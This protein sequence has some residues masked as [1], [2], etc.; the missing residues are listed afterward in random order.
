MRHFK[1][2]LENQASGARTCSE[3]GQQLH[4]LGCATAARWQGGSAHTSSSLGFQ[5]TGANSAAVDKTAL[6][7]TG[8]C[9]TCPLAACG[10]HLSTHALC[11]GLGAHR[12]AGSAL[13]P[14]LNDIPARPRGI[15]ARRA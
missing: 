2:F 11:M 10:G 9:P 1:H 13:S 3:A 12:L 15:Q 14:A 8:A 7:L 6:A 5:Q 4:M